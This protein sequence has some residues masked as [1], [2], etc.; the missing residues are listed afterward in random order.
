[1]VNDI[2]CSVLVSELSSRNLQR[3]HN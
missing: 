3:R 1:V 2:F